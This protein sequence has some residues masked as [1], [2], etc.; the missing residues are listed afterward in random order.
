MKYLSLFLVAILL[1][2][3][4][5]LADNNKDERGKLFIIGGGKR[6]INLIQKMLDVTNLQDS[7]YIFI[8]PM[9]SSEPDTSVYYI[10]KQINEITSSKIASYDFKKD[11]Y[12]LKELI[13]SLEKAK[14][15]FITG[16]DQNKF[17]DAVSG[18]KVYDAL[19]NA[20]KNGATIAGTSAGAAIQSKK[21]ITGNEL[22]HS[23]YSSNFRTIE[24]NNIELK[25][26]MG[27]VSEIIVDQ[28][29]VKRMRMNR[30]LS[31][32]IENPN[33]HCLG[34]D[35][36]T[37]IIYEKG[38]IEVVGIGQ[39]IYIKNNEA[40][41]EIKDGLLGSKNIN[42]KVLLPGDKLSLK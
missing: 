12:I 40:E 5:N 3:C 17:M 26:G 41:S 25:E 1:S 33:E 37:A 10:S 23:E 9:A 21:M 20:Y 16:G 29:F 27:F 18:S 11:E 19:H 14:L 24:S 22:K 30:L 7:D 2:S 39:V 15:I 38:E 31:V 28:H 4:S 34:I 32:A 8:L 13:D 35:E 36:S 6:P 42:V